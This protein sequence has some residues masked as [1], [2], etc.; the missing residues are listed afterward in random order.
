MTQVTCRKQ[1]ALGHVVYQPPAAA[2][3]ARGERAAEADSRF[4]LGS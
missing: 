3:P 2:S 4:E 1:E